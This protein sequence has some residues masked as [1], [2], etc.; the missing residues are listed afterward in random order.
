MRVF[1]LPALLVAGI[2]TSGCATVIKGTDQPVA[3]NTP[4]A[5][6]AVC[7]LTSQSIGTYTVKTP[8]NIVLPKSRKDIAVMCKKECYEDSGGVIQS[9]MAGAT[10][11]NI[12]LGG[13]IGFGVD[14]M[15]GAMHKY[16][17]SITVVMKKKPGCRAKRA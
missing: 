7:E 11:G 4:G 6:G 1:V 14:A 13:V 10:A 12:I 15:S 5:D 16:Q 2:Y 17:P 9:R 8:G 3:V